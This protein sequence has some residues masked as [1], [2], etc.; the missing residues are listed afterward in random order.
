MDL[1]WLEDV[2]Q[3]KTPRRLPVVLTATEVRTLLL[4]H[5]QGTTGLIAQLLYGTGMRLLEAL[6]LRVRMWNLPGARL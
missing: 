4:L 2:V 5:M 3:A 6:R 1:P